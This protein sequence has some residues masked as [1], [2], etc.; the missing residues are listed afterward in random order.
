MIL[1]IKG[2]R[3]GDHYHVIVY[4][5]KDNFSLAKCGDLCFRKEEWEILIASMGA[6]DYPW[7]K[8]MG[9]GYMQLVLGGEHMTIIVQ[10]RFYDKT[11]C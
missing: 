7:E 5:G 11:E 10:E 4:M 2:E 1:K 6:K 3:A 8:L 9:N